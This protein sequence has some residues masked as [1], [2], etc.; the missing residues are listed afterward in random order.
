VFSRDDLV[1]HVRDGVSRVT[2]CNGVINESASQAVSESDTKEYSSSFPKRRESVE[3][4]CLHSSTRPRSRG[5]RVSEDHVQVRF[6]L[7][8]MCWD[9]VE[10]MGK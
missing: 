9:R 3:R 5:T 1:R 8:G 6:G 2:N 10:K 4:R 7:Q